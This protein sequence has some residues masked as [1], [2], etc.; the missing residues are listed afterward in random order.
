MNTV[1]SRSC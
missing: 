1:K